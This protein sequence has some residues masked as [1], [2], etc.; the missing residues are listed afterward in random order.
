LAWHYQRKQCAR[1][2]PDALLYKGRYKGRYKDRY[3][4]AVYVGSDLDI[5]PDLDGVTSLAP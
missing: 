5:D 1:T 3:K 2:D 4:A